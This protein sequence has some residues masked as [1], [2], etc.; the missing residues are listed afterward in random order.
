MP[1]I[2]EKTLGGLSL[3]YYLRHFIFGLIFSAIIIGISLQQGS[4][5]K[6][7]MIVMCIVSSVLYPY[8][9][10][11]YESIMDFIL[12]NNTFFVNSIFFIFV[13]ILSMLL[14]WSFAIFIAPVGFLYLYF[15][16]SRS[17]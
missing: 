10:F 11:V 2:I 14:C 6:V 17:N 13:K 8:S 4:T 12:G 1:P 15:Y 5:I 7:D 9:R 16:H 3:Q